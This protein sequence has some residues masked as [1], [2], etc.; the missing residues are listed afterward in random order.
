MRQSSPGGVSSPAVASQMRQSSPGRVSS[1]TVAAETRQ[2]SPGGVRTVASEMRQLSPGRMSSQLVSSEMRPTLPSRL[3][4]S[5][6]PGRTF[7]GDFRAGDREGAGRAQ[8]YSLQM[9]PRHAQDLI[10]EGFEARPSGVFRQFSS[11]MQQLSPGRQQVVPALEQ[12]EQNPYVKHAVA[13]SPRGVPEQ[14]YPSPSGSPQGST[15]LFG[16]Q[17][18]GRT[19]RRPSSPIGTSLAG[20]LATSDGQRRLA[21]HAAASLDG[22]ELKL[23]SAVFELTDLGLLT[24]LTAKLGLHWS[25]VEL[26]RTEGGGMNQGIWRM[27]APSQTYVLKLVSSEGIVLSNGA[28]LS[29]DADRYFDLCAQHPRIMRDPSIAFP[30]KVF[31][32]RGSD[33]SRPHDLI[34][35]IRAPGEVLSD[36]IAKL[37]LD[38]RREELLC[39]LERFGRFLADFHARYDGKQHGDCQPSNICYDDASQSF[40]M[41]D[42]ATMMASRPGADTEQFMKS[43]TALS[44]LIGGA[45][46]GSALKRHFA[47]GYWNSQPDC[48]IS[49]IQG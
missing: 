42:A 10:W 46:F 44:N 39:L 26:E 1:R 34:V 38:G 8:T 13:L 30:I 27:Y 11:Q 33:G 35:M 47:L 45:S 24:P 31:R 25:D 7:D 20:M 12:R 36:A 2:S 32:I 28:M 22:G 48:A 3:S 40:T 18:Y 14:R 16:S 4:A 19:S 49:S 43:L 23:S 37:A 21:S 41:L 17:E 15:R 29:S 5:L 9:S 6:G